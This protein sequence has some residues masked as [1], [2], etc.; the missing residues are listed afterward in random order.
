[1][2]QTKIADITVGHRFRKDMGDID[3]LANSIQANGLLQPIGI[4][5]DLQLVFGGRR[6][7]ACQS[8]GLTE[9]DTKVIDCDALIAEQDENTVRKA[10]CISEQVAIADAI[11]AKLADRRGGDR[12]SD[13]AGNISGLIDKGETRDIAAAKAGLGSG[14][15]YEAAK[16]VI[17]TGSPAL[18]S[19]LDEGKL[20]INSASKLATLPIDVQESIDYSNDKKIRG[21]AWTIT[22]REKRNAEKESGAIVPSGKQKPEI[23]PDINRLYEKGSSLSAHVLAHRANTAIVQIGRCDPNAIAAI[24]SIQ[25]TLNHQLEAITKGV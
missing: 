19:A 3:A 21:Q 10:F 2:A 11:A 9:I 20:T 7:K 8:L 13:Q 25:A 14:K 4:T 15:T 22:R 16:K 1:M 17:Q 6:L 23:Q 5:P 12:K 18:V 24:Q